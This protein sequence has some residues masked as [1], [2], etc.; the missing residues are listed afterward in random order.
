M[1]ALVSSSAVTPE[2]AGADSKGRVWSAVPGALL[3]L[4]LVDPP[5]T[6]ARVDSGSLCLVF[7]QR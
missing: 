4:C 3:A 5:A 6:D 7:Q 2:T 1:A